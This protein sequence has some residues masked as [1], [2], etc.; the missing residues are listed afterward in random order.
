MKMMEAR[1]DKATNMEAGELTEDV[2]KQLEERTAES[3]FF[4][5][6][7]CGVREF[8]VRDGHV[9]SKFG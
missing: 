2:S 9:Y 7:S 8:E 4:Y 1:F 3:K 5:D 6:S